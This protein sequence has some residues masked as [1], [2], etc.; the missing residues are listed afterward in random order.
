MRRTPTTAERIPALRW[1]SGMEICYRAA[2]VMV[3][4]GN[5]VKMVGIGLASVIFM[6]WFIVGL[7]VTSQTQSSSPFGLHLCHAISRRINN[8]LHLPDDRRGVWRPGWWPLFL[9]G[10]LIAAQ[11]QLLMSHADSAVHT[12]PFLSHEQTR[13][14]DVFDSGNASTSSYASPRVSDGRCLMDIRLAMVTDMNSQSRK[15][16]KDRPENNWQF[17]AGSGCCSCCSMR[18]AGMERRTGVKRCRA[19]RRENPTLH[20]VRSRRRTS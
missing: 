12:S 19:K 3:G 8:V 14:G 6:F 18:R 11:G 1:S 13:G 4:L 10:V 17:L 20:Q 7:A 2:R 5:T 16:G 15:L 9:L